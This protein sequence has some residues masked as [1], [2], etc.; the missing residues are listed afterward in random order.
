MR[1][2]D[3]SSPRVGRFACGKKMTAG[4]TGQPAGALSAILQRQREAFLRDGPPS[5]KRRRTDLIK[6][7]Q[8]I[9]DSSDRIAE[10]ISADFGRIALG[11]K[12]CSLKCTRPAAQ[13]AIRYGTWQDG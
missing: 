13:F 5:L 2:T 8:A 7:R 6:L 3:K 4:P 10:V 1:A 12:V 11:T 9:K